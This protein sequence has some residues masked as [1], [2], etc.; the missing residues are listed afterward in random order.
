MLFTLIVLSSAT[1]EGS[2]AAPALA[3]PFVE[4]WNIPS[5]KVDND[6]TSLC[7]DWAAPYFSFDDGC[8]GLGGTNL[9][10]DG[11][12][13]EVADAKFCPD[14]TAVQAWSVGEELEFEA[15]YQHSSTLEESEL[16]SFQEMVVER[17][18][19]L[20]IHPWHMILQNQ[21]HD[22]QGR[23]R[24]QGYTHKFRC[25]GGGGGGWRSYEKGVRPIHLWVRSGALID[26]LEFSYADG[27]KLSGGGSGGGYSSISLPS[28]IS[29][30]YIRWGALVDGIQ[31]FG[32][33]SQTPYYGGHGGG[34]NIVVAPPGRCLGDIKMKTGALVDQICLKFNGCD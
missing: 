8:I 4:P 32:D 30:V 3:T 10:G 15:L 24:I 29:L 31:F 18:M 9:S 28:C 16:Q 2:K 17:E 20:A 27:G 6:C 13:V 14:K 21:I 33:G 1:E 7:Q 23:R 34:S 11:D 25:F 12:T 19:K 5:I 22:P 26:R